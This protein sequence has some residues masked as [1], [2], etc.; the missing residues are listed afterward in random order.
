MNFDLFSPDPGLHAYVYGYAFIDCAKQDATSI[1]KL[2]PCG[3]IIVHFKIKGTLNVFSQK[4]KPVSISSACIVGQI[5]KSYQMELANSCMLFSIIFQPTGFYHLTGIKPEPFTNRLINIHKIGE[6]WQILAE[7]FSRQSAVEGILKVCNL[8]LLKLLE[9][10]NPQ[11]ALNVDKFMRL[12]EEFAPKACLK[13]ISSHIYVCERQIRRMVKRAIGISPKTFLRILR[14]HYAIQLARK[15]TQPNYCDIVHSCGYT[16]QAHFSREFKSLVGTNPRNY[17]KQ[18][19]ES[20][21]LMVGSL[22]SS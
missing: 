15:S 4:N 10:S 21:E 22:S 13:D 1:L 5:T 3:N 17:F 2:L 16:D 14:L 19:Y 18:P 20:M 6:C 8:F 11:P 12:A 9:H 7:E